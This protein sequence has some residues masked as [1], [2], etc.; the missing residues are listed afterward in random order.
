MD[1]TTVSLTWCFS[2]SQSMGATQTLDVNRQEAPEGAAGQ[3]SFIKWFAE[4]SIEDVPEVGGKNASLG[5]MYRELAEQGVKVPNGFALTADAYRFFLRESGLDREIPEMLAGLD[6]ADVEDLR[7]RGRL[8][9]ERITEAPLPAALA[10]PL[11][12]AY[13]ELC[14][15]EGNTVSVAV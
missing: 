7:R 6:T 10:A 9:R 12:D 8:I 5:E 2:E 11:R 1:L 15:V 3:T 14:R 4:I 13:D